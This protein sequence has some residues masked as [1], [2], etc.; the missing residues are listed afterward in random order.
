M[1]KVVVFLLGFLCGIAVL[2]IGIDAYKF[3]KKPIVYEAKSE[4]RFNNGMVIP[5]G[6]T[7]YQTAKMPE[8]YNVLR[9][10]IQIF[11]GYISDF[12]MEREMKETDIL[13]HW[14]DKKSVR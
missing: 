7:L 14:L 3:S 10:D 9:I 2:A 13:S 1:N 6:A 12:F 8:G 4:I 11:R 5:K